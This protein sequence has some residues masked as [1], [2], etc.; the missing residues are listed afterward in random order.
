MAKN[1]LTQLIN[2]K[3]GDNKQLKDQVREILMNFHYS[4]IAEGNEWLGQKN[5]ER[6]YTCKRNFEMYRREM[7][8]YQE[9]N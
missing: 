9:I 2:Q 8:K 7:V 6:R 3:L 4:C 5:I 1:E